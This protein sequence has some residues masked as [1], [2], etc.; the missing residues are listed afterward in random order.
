MGS[1]HARLPVI[2]LIACVA[3]H[4]RRTFKDLNSIEFGDCRHL[5]ALFIVESCLLE[6]ELLF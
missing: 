4:V 1:L 5:D 6:D 2:K 3:G